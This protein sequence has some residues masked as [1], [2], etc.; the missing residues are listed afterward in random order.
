MLGTQSLWI[1]FRKHYHAR[2]QYRSIHPM[3]REIR[4][5]IISQHPIGMF[6]HWILWF[7]LIMA[8]YGAV[9]GMDVT[10]A[11]WSSILKEHTKEGLVDY[12]GLKHDASSL[13]SY[14]N[15]LANVGSRE[16]KDWPLDDQLAFLINLYNA[17]TVRLI[18]DEYP[19]KSIQDIGILPHAAWRKKFVSLWGKKVSLNH[20]EHELI[21]PRATQIPDIHFA[22]V[23]AAMGCPP[24]RE[25]AYTA[26]HLRS[27]L[28]DQGTQ[29]LS[30][31]IKNSINKAEKTLFLSPI[32]DWYKS[33]FESSYKS[34]PN[35]L[36]KVYP[37][38][39]PVETRD[40]KIEFTPYDWGLNAKTRK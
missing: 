3:L 12:A 2:N 25:E 33:D 28:H 10:H 34:I 4:M 9:W 40:Y 1:Q 30:N 32:F 31:P 11:V 6:K 19:I 20:I 16:F 37:D 38:L 36:I 24:L 13:D 35:Y 22:L 17:A 27:Q 14:L 23:C 15:S 7:M 18:L 21:R 5:S 26:D 39:F 8:S 29:F